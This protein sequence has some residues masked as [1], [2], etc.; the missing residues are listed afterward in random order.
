MSTRVSTRFILVTWQTTWCRRLFNFLL[1]SQTPRHLASVFNYYSFFLHVLTL[2][3]EDSQA[4]VD[5][6]LICHL[7]KLFTLP[8]RLAGFSYLLEFMFVGCRQRDEISLWDFRSYFTLLAH[9][10]H[11][12]M[13]VE[14][15]GCW[16]K[17]LCF[18]E[19]TKQ[20]HTRNAHLDHREG[21]SF[22]HTPEEP[23]IVMNGRVNTLT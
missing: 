15:C 16:E 10:T 11:S 2:C 7:R 12:T 17:K 18:D 8:S 13:V 14:R 9:H 1:A 4:S 22:Q 20:F 5:C 6:L 19:R 23:R 21:I 3:S